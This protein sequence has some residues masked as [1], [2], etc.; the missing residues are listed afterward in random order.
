[1][2]VAFVLQML[3]WGWWPEDYTYVS[4]G[5]WESKGAFSAS[6]AQTQDAFPMTGNWGCANFGG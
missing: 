3:F 1:L 2:N 4:L 6:T 5:I